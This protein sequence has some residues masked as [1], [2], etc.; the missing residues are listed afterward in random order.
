MLIH[1]YSMCIIRGKWRLL[2]RSAT[3]SLR[4]LIELMQIQDKLPLS[5]WIHLGEGALAH[6]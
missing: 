3:Y 4:R 2:P 1:G 5:R 6:M